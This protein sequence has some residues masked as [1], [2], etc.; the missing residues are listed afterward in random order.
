[1]SPIQVIEKVQA[2]LEDAC[3]LM[4]YD[5]ASSPRIEVHEE[6]HAARVLL[7]DLK[8]ALLEEAK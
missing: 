2:H 1:M 4:S 6:I 5:K 3:T 7:A 8:L